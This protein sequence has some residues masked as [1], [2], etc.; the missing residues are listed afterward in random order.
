MHGGAGLHGQVKGGTRST[1]RRHEGSARRVWTRA[2][3]VHAP[4]AGDGVL[5]GAAQE[6]RGKLLVLLATRSAAYRDRGDMSDAT[7]TEPTATPELTE[8]WRA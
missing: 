1:P 5:A 3:R 6:Q 2:E 7:S 4:G 8:S